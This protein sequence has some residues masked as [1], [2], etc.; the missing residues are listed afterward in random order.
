MLPLSN[1]AA[2]WD[3]FS[4]TL[5]D[6]PAGT[7]GL[8]AKTTWNLRRK[9]T[10]ALDGNG[11]ATVNFTGINPTT[12]KQLK[13][14]DIASAGPAPAYGPPDNQ[15]QLYDY[16]KLLANWHTYTSGADI[17]GNGQVSTGD[18]NILSSNWYTVGDPQ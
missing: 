17:D 14:G 18:Y 9:L 16:L 1:T 12:G 15:I 6:V 7:T 11:Q 5:T 8:S 10:L 2:P 13:G 4:Y 3:T